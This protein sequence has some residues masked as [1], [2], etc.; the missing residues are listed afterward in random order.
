MPF[1]PS[2]LQ[3]RA[4][5]YIV[6]PKNF[7]APYMIMAFP[8]KNKAQKDLIAALHPYDYTARPQII[9]KDWNPGYYKVLKT[10]EEITGVG[11]VLNTSFNLQVPL[12]KNASD[13]RQLYLNTAERALIRS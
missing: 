2:I 13:N 11:G 7:Y 5:D 4:N 10:F 9:S 1:A 8:T 6:N 3:E 12:D